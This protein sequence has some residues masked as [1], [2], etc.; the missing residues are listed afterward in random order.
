MQLCWQVSVSNGKLFKETNSQTRPADDLVSVTA[1]PCP[2][3]HFQWISS[4]S[5][6]EV[7]RT[8][9]TLLKKRRNWEESRK[10]TKRSTMGEKEYDDEAGD[11]NDDEK[12][13]V[14]IL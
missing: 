11:E 2:D 14:Q 1:E 13:N 10:R 3:F 5:E 8:M 12:S 4:T 6:S 9:K 7:S